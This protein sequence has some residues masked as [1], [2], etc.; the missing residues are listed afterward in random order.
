MSTAEM[1]PAGSP[2]TRKFVTGSVVGVVVLA[3]ATLIAIPIAA[4][5]MLSTGFLRG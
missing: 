2:V 4:R 3:A 1:E 5:G